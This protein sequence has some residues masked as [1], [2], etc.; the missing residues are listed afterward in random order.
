MDFGVASLDQAKVAERLSRLYRLG[1]I[2]GGRRAKRAAGRGDS[3]LASRGSFRAE[4]GSGAAEIEPDIE[5]AAA[6]LEPESA[7]FIERGGHLIAALE[8]ISPRNKDRPAARGAC[9]NRYL[10][11]LLDAVHLVLIDLH[12]RPLAFS[13]ADGIAEELRIAQT[14]C[15]SPFANAYRVG[16]PAAEGGRLLAIWRR[17]LESGAPLP[18]LPL[19]L[20]EHVSVL[21]DL[22]ATYSQAAADA[23]VS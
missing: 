16:T 3:L 23:Y 4:P 9:L 13:F 7:L 19:P 15:P 5:I 11:Y 17:P 18:N 8:L 22:E 20:N 2:V 6:V 14:H 12:P 1:P 10:G 21:L